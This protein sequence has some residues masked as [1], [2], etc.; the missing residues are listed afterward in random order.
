[1]R[2]NLQFFGGRGASAGNASLDA[3][4]KR[5][6]R[7]DQKARDYYRNVARDALDQSSSKYDNYTST[8]RNEIRKTW[9]QYGDEAREA[10][11][12]YL[13]RLEEERKKQRK[14][15]QERNY[16]PTTQRE[17][18]SSTYKRADKRTQKLVLRNM[19]Y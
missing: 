2:Y 19:G 9:Q 7:L 10:E 13:A 12:K 16:K 8:E 15:T 18:T 14:K 17:I 5:A 4:K 3:L 6:D 1:M 11:N